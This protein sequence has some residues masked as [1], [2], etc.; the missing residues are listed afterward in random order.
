MLMDSGVG[1][2]FGLE[3]PNGKELWENAIALNTAR[4]CL[5]YIIRSYSIKEIFVPGYTCPVVWE[6]IMAENCGMSFYAIDENFMPKQVFPEGA[7][8]L[9]TNYFGV[10]K[11]NIQ[12]LSKKY[13]RL[14]VDNSQSFFCARA[15]LA[16]FN[17]A[18]KFFGTTDG[19]YL[20]SDKMIDAE[21]FEKDISCDRFNYMLIRTELGAEKGYGAFLQNE[22]LLCNEEIKHMS[23]LTRFVLKGIDYNSVSEK[24]RSNFLF[25]H[26]KLNRFNLWKGNIDENEVP[27]IYPF[28]YENEKL[29]QIL[30]D[31]KIFVARYWKGQRDEETGRFFEKHLIPL[32][33][34]QRYSSEDMLRITNCVLANL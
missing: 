22:E 12:A 1:G 17:S 20:F 33:V 23:D 7:Y 24:R 2:Y 29:R 15:G 3:I 13:P 25:L 10:C 32:P 8:I 19:A 27:L 31:E 14:I 4:N 21:K 26:E 34:D 11:R 28:V 30:I 18:R 6:A 16:S 5:R 9:Y